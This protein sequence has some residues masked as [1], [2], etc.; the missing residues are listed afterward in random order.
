MSPLDTNWNSGKPA[1]RRAVGSPMWH[2]CGAE[3]LSLQERRRVCQGGS[4]GYERCVQPN[5]IV[6]LCSDTVPKH[7]GGRIN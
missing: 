7:S 2:F 4:T 3:L 1:S 6:A 5:S